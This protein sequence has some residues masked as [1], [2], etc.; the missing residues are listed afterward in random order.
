[1]TAPRLTSRLFLRIDPLTRDR[2][3]ALSDA[4]ERTASELV[5][6][7]VTSAFV[8]KLAAHG[9]L[10]P[11]SHDRAA[12]PICNMTYSPKEFLE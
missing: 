9:A 10:P 12:C 3:R 7:L 1:M 8:E 2:L 6:R 4:D 5:R 11:A